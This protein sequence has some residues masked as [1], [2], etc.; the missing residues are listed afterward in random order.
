MTLGMTIQVDAAQAKAMMDSLGLSTDQLAAKVA[1]GGKQ[2]TAGLG[3][4]REAARLLSEDMGTHLPRAITSAIGRMQE[5]QAIAGVAFQAGVAIFAVER[6]FAM[7]N[8]LQGLVDDMNQLKLAEQLLGEAVQQNNEVIAKSAQISAKAAQD[9]LK[10]LN[11]QIAAQQD[12][13]EHQRKLIDFEVDQDVL[14]GLL[15]AK[16]TGQNK[17]LADDETALQRLLKLRDAII[18]GLGDTE[19]KSHERAAAA[20]KKFNDEMAKAIQLTDREAEALERRLVVAWEKETKAE[21]IAIGIEEKHAITIREVGKAI[22]QAGLQSSQAIAAAA[23]SVQ[24]ALAVFPQLHDAIEEYA[25]APLI[26]LRE[27]AAS[28]F[29]GL[30]QGMIQSAAAALIYGDSIGASLLRAAKSVLA[31]IA[32]EAAVK[33]VFQLAEGYAN[34]AAFQFEAAALNFTA[35]KT[36]GAIA[37]VSLAA[38]IGLRGLGGSAGPSAGFGALAGAGPPTGGSP[39]ASGPVAIRGSGPAPAAIQVKVELHGDLAPLVQKISAEV[40]QGK[41]NLHSSTSSRVIVRS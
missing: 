18:S 12:S 4:S 5:F 31:S 17:K 35:A 1:G 26:D 32:A 14:L 28:A 34:A 19:E 38:G 24:Q 2:M 15:F 9:Q 3:S 11:V 6:V 13:I 27:E 36:Y 37:G 16:A 30:A 25:I 39:S 10:L 8:A 22:D 40:K 33:S 41:Y 23:T 7:G 21:L 20:R 29:S